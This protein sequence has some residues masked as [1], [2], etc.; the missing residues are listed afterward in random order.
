MGGRLEQQFSE[1]DS[2]LRKQPS[3]PLIFN[4]EV[5]GALNCI[6]RKR[7]ACRTLGSES[8]V[9]S[10][11]LATGLELSLLTWRPG[12]RLLV[13]Q[14]CGFWLPLPPPRCGR[15]C[16]AWGDTLASATATGPR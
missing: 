10:G 15:S 1:L 2:N 7:T 4:A 11:R 5:P 3:R 16:G 8:C 13:R 14:A 6:R 12:F 9:T